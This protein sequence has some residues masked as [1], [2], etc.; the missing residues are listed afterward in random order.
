MDPGADA[1]LG[2]MAATR[3]SGT[4]AVRCGTMGEN[5]L[6]L[7][8]VLAD[9]RIIKT[10]GHA[11]KSAA[12]YDLTR[13]FVGYE[14]TLGEITEVQLRLCGIPEAMSVAVCQFESLGDAVNSVIQTIQTGIP[15]AHIELLDDVQMRACFNYSNLKGYAAKATLMFEFHGT[16]ASVKE[17]ADM[18][19]AITADFGGGDFK[20]TVHAE[21][22]NKLWQARQMPTT[23]HS[24]SDQVSKAWQP[25]S[26]YRSRSLPNACS[27]PSAT[28]IDPT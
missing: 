6:G 19:G 26:A 3:A 21:D 14:E 15:V 1:S 9:G 12:G 20:W 24:N 22:R 13:L 5:V 7:T 8:V 23:R 17:Q 25:T 18:M 16:D 4:N 28:S 11:R 2:G 27:R 10:G